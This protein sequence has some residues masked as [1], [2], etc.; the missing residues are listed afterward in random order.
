MNSE[1]GAAAASSVDR[2][3]PW[4]RRSVL[5]V[6]AI[7]F[8]VLIFI[9]VK[10]HYDAPPIP[11]R[12]VDTSGA[13]VFDSK[14]VANGQE[15]FLKYGLMDNGTIWGHG[16]YLGPDFSAQYLHTL[17]LDVADA[18]A[19]ERFG[20][21]YDDLAVDEKAMVEALTRFSR[22]SAISPVIST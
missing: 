13:L 15:V 2:L 7:G 11:A 9:T 6:M 19:R 10:V 18:F 8:S 16:A 12:V 14:D 20:R 4:W 5:I 17:G 22:R 1:T 21:P 3:S